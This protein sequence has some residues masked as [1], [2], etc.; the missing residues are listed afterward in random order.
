MK[1][2][3]RFLPLLAAFTCVCVLPK[4]GNA[5][6]ISP[7]DAQIRPVSGTLFEVAAGSQ[8]AVFFVT[9]DGIILVDPLNRGT[10]QWLRDALAT[11]FPDRPV[12]YVVYS[13]HHFDR[14][15]GAGEFGLPQVVAHREFNGALDAADR[16]L[17]SYVSVTDTNG[18]GKYDPTEIEGSRDAA[19]ILSKDRNGDGVVTAE[20]LYARVRRA[21]LTYSKELTL[22]LAGKSVRLIHPGPAYSLDMTVVY[23][24]DERV[25]FA[26]NGPAVN[27]APFSFGLFR[28]R[29]VY[30]WIH[31]ITRLDFDTLLFG[32]GQRMTRADLVALVD[33]LDAVRA[34][35]GHGLERGESIARVQARSAAAPYTTSPHAADRM[36]QLAVLY[37]STRLIKMQVSAVA[38]GNYDRVDRARCSG[39]TTCAIGGALPATTVSAA[40]VLG[41]GLGVAGELTLERQAWNTRTRPLYDEE[42][43][44][45]QSRGSVLLRFGPRRDSAFAY[46]IVGGVTATVGDARGVTHVRGS[47]V[48][49]GGWQLVHTNDT[50]LGL[51]VGGD[52]SIGRGLALVIP[53]RLSQTPSIAYYW[54]SRLNLRA[55]IGITAPVFHRIR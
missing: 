47:F 42:I 53:V 49:A 50:R 40:L 37:R 19:L 27:H 38:V 9:P 11:R 5:Q 54:P 8:T 46:A 35:V 23:F 17:P 7:V 45:R 14:A 44:L 22:T 55:G 10:A 48:P 36:T 30:E 4:S 29:D 6:A 32:D 2:P 18:N 51:T 3:Q 26:A 12:R 52:I 25:V 33:Y 24:P 43:A 16:T 15:E 1:L 31:A 41:N 34:D 28:P 20:E 21:R 13:H 39:Y